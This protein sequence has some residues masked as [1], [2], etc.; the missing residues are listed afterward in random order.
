[1]AEMLCVLTGSSSMKKEVGL[2]FLNSILPFRF[3][4]RILSSQANRI[5]ATF[6]QLNR[7][8]SSQEK[9]SGFK[10]NSTLR[11]TILIYFY[12]QFVVWVSQ[13]EVMQHAPTP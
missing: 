8:R 13:K 6:M 4:W 2:S 10:L 12:L 11:Q 3:L 7:S 5:Q 1:M 9:R